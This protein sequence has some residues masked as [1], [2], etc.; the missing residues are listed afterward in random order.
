MDDVE[1]FVEH[2]QR[3]AEQF[4]ELLRAKAS[5]HHE[6]HRL[7][8]A[9]PGKR[10]RALPAA[11]VE[12]G[13]DGGARKDALAMRHVGQRIFKAHADRVRKARGNAVAQS[14]R[15]VRL[16]RDNG[17]LTRREHN[18]NGDESALAEDHVRLEFVNQLSR[19]KISLDHAEGVDKILPG[20]IPPE[21]AGGNSVIG[22]AVD[23]G[24]QVVFHAALRADVVHVPALAEQRLHECDV[25]GNV[26]GRAAAGKDD[27]CGSVRCGFHMCVSP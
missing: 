8:A 11:F 26:P 17:N 25:W 4:V 16:V 13:S 7:G 14:R 22:H 2:G 10:Q 18:G 20:K 21:F 27:S 1:R 5:A 15:I 24:D 6:Q 19:L 12:R 3:S 23:S 9:Q